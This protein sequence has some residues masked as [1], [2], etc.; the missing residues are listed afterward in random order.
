MDIDE[1]LLAYKPISVTLNFDWENTTYDERVQMRHDYIEEQKKTNPNY[2]GYDFAELL[3]S[4]YGPGTKYGSLEPLKS[5]T[6]LISTIGQ[7]IRV[8]PRGKILETTMGTNDNN[9]KHVTMTFIGKI[10][11]KCRV[12][13]LLASTFIP[14][15]EHLKEHRT[16][17][18]INHKNDV[19]TCNLR[20][21]LEWCTGLENTVKSIET[22]ARETKSYMATWVVEDEFKGSEFYFKDLKELR[23]FVPYGNI[24]QAIHGKLKT[25][26]GCTWEYVDKSY[27]EGK[28]TGFPEH[29][30]VLLQDSSYINPRTQPLLAEIKKKGVYYGL[31]FALLGIN[32]IKNCGFCFPNIGK[33][34][35]GL[36][37]NHKG[38]TWTKCTLVES[39]KHQRGLTK[40]QID[41]LRD[42]NGSR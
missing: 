27:F 12:H 5:D 42:K 33:V 24:H 41:F 21:N 23:K 4:E 2:V 3:L 1:R 39:K 19:K 35:R 29:I 17:L 16:H 6:S 32:E 9:Y 18:V 26:Y 10:H 34:L 14:I 22:G 13:R 36:R 31:T 40:E 15:P 20:T 38:C 28:K 25:Q 30:T 37:Q 11:K 7:I 8:N